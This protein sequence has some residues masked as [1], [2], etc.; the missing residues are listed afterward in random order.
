MLISHILSEDLSNFDL[1]NLDQ[2]RRS[3]LYAQTC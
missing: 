2:T 3:Q 1:A